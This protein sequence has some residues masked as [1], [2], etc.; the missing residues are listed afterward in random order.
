MA[1]RS[2][3]SGN[4]QPD[5]FNGLGIQRVDG[6]DRDDE[7]ARARREMRDTGSADMFDAIADAT[8]AIAA[9][10][11]EGVAAIQWCLKCGATQSTSCF[12]R[13]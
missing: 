1:H 4:W 2:V 8:T 6:I 5:Q 9:C 7:F 12:E 3:S 10:E 11:H 13:M